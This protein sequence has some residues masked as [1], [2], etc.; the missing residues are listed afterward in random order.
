MNWLVVESAT[1][2]EYSEEHETLARQIILYVELFAMQSASSLY[3]ALSYL[4]K[5]SI[6]NR[7]RLNAKVR[8]APNFNRFWVWPV[9]RIAFLIKNAIHS[10]YH[11]AKTAKTG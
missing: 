2:W 9:V 5:V 6:T 8:V 1:I 7:T 11:S 4:Y 3:A 10:E